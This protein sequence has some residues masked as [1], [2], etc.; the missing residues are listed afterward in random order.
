MLDDLGNRRHL[1]TQNK[2]L[3]LNEAI[4]GSS[5]KGPS[6]KGTT[7]ITKDTLLDPFPIA[8]VHFK[9]PR[10]GQPLNSGQSGLIPRCP[11][12]GGSTVRLSKSNGFTIF[13]WF[14]ILL[15]Q[16]TCSLVLYFDQNHLLLLLR[17]QKEESFRFPPLCRAPRLP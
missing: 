8:V 17:R 10:K 9:P 15:L 11:L 16:L 5:D 13:H 12:F 3:Q 4:S 1:Q 7:S 14:Q 2:P 6:E